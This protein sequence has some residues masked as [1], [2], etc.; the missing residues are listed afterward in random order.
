MAT[1]TTENAVDFDRVGLTFANGTTALTDVSLRI[2]KG[3]FVS[4]VGPSGCGKST[5][6][7]IASGLSAATAGQC[8]V[9]RSHVGYVFQDAT[10]LPWR[11]ALRNVEL[12]GELSGARSDKAARKAAAKRTLDEVGLAGFEDH[13][14]H[15][16][17]GGMRMRVSLARSLTIEPDLFLFDEPFGALDEITRDRLNDL[18]FDL[19]LEHG[20]AGMFVTHSV[21]EAVA[22][23]TRVVVMTGRPGSII[24]EFEV[25]FGENRGP[26]LRESPEFADLVARVG[27]SLRGASVV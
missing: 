17:S 7:R 26:E 2:R 5:L 6:L 22:M 24:E 16:L 14:P 3:E 25:P 4:I 23:S 13:L 12:F 10:L 19:F 18:V 9:A 20:F 27:H 15:Q 11:T 1:T 8:D 21:R